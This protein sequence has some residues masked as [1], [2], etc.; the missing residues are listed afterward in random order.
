MTGPSLAELTRLA[1][2]R[3]GDRC[4]YCRMVQALQGGT[5]HLEHVQPVSLGGRTH[6][7]NLAWACPA[8]N[9]CKSNNRMGATGRARG[10]FAA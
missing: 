2:E 9:L 4:E 7:D 5:F 6:L 3:A 10:C 8:C 1:R